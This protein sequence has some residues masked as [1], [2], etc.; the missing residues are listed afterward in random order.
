MT[1][2]DWKFREAEGPPDVHLIK[3]VKLRHG[4]EGGSLGQ[5]GF[6][7]TATACVSGQGAG[8]VGGRGGN[9]LHGNGDGIL[10]YVFGFGITLC[11]DERKEFAF[12]RGKGFGGDFIAGFAGHNT[13]G[14]ILRNGGD[15]GGLANHFAID[16]DFCSLREGIDGKFL[17]PHAGNQEKSNRGHAED[18][19][20]GAYCS[21]EQGSV[22]SSN[23]V[24]A[25]RGSVC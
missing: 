11:P 3:S 6:G 16:G 19:L 18:F 15:Q 9:F 24:L 1:I 7:G 25:L 23:Y 13:Q 12:Y 22:S 21:A 20:H 10:L 8:G 14:L 17:I 2:D 4:A 5:D